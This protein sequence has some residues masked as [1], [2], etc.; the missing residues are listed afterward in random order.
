[1]KSNLVW[2]FLKHSPGHN[3]G[4]VVEVSIVCELLECSDIFKKYFSIVFDFICG[5]LIPY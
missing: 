3:P 1:M 2:N 4:D 5:V